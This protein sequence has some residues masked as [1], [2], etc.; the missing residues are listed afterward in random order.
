M[1]LT[2]RALVLGLDG[3]PYSLLT[4]L[5]GNGELPHI[6]ALAERGSLASSTVVHPAISSV[7]WSSFMT[8]R[9]PEQH[10][11]YGFTALDRNYRFKLPSFAHLQC[12]TIF[13]RLGQNGGRSVVINLPAT[14]PARAIPGTLVS[15]FVAPRLENAVAPATLLP[16]LQAMGYAVDIDLP[17]CRKDHDELFRQLHRS[18]QQ[19]TAL[20]DRLWGEA[21][22]LFM[23]VV[24]GTDRLHHFLFDAA[25]DCAHPRHEA[26]I[27]Y[28]RAVDTLVGTLTGRFVQQHPD[29]ML[30]LLSDHGFTDNHF[31]VNINVLLEQEGYLQYATNEPKLPSDIRPEATRVFAM[32]PARIHINSTDAF[33]GGIVPP[34][35]KAHIKN[36]LNALFVRLE[37]NGTPVIS[38]VLDGSILYPDARNQGTPDLLLVPVKGFNLKASV[39]AR[40][41]FTHAEL[42]GMHTYDDAFCLVCPAMESVSQ[43]AAPDT[44]LGASAFV[45]SWFSRSGRMIAGQASAPVSLDGKIENAKAFLRK[46]LEEYAGSTAACWTGGKDSTLMLWLMRTV[47]LEAGLSMPP[48]INIDEGDNFP[49]LEA[50]VEHYTALWTIPLTIIRNEDLLSKS[51][52]TGSHVFVQEM[53]DM[54]RAALAEIGYTEAVFVFEP[55]SIAGNHLTKTLPLREYVRSRCVRGLFVALRHDEHSARSEETPVSSRQNP[56]HDRLH[57][58]LEFSERD[59]WDAIFHLGIP[60]S[61]LYAQG[62]RSLGAR[63]NTVPVME[64]VPAWEQDIENTSERMGRGQAKEQVMGQL[65]TLGY[66]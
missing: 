26:F 52:G 18:L 5:M 41:V 29:G 7:S 25:Y 3:V 21:W 23:L 46:A 19:R 64:G 32:D 53:S 24:T 1:Q 37:Y 31:E 51:R 39:S 50:F 9:P 22:N 16:E 17:R 35:D 27:A 45:E 6:T 62:Y 56:D 15:G 2:R 4:H 8:G 60:Y 57:P 34:E 47:C 44:L 59:V 54:N 30:L 28:Y 61:E 58:I 65:R 14:Y 20:A 38:E 66:M 33:S 11:I 48:T 13:D 55:E 12:D 49:E 40:A 10:G 42:S 36:E 63:Y 43:P